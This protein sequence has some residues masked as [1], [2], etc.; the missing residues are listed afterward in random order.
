[1]N[2]SCEANADDSERGVV[3]KRSFGS[4]LGRRVCGCSLTHSV[5]Y[6]RKPRDSC[7]ANIKADQHQI[8]NA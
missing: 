8:T 7:G 3:F 1:M 2:S 6:C 5:T 4:A